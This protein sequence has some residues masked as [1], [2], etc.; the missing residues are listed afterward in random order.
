MNT[1]CVQKLLPRHAHGRNGR[2]SKDALLL[3][4]IWEGPGKESQISTMIV[5]NDYLSPGRSADRARHTLARA[6]AAGGYERFE[7]EAGFVVASRL[8]ATDAKELRERDPS[9]GPRHAVPNVFL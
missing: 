9:R 8:T 4:H 7:P 1:E 3:R 6:T 5:I 2:N